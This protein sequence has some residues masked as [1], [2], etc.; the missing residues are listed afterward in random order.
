MLFLKVYFLSVFD[1]PPLI[2]KFSPSVLPSRFPPKNGVVLL[3]YVNRCIMC[4]WR[5]KSYNW[6]WNF[7]GNTTLHKCAAF[8]CFLSPVKI[9][10]L[11]ESIYVSVSVLVGALCSDLFCLT[12]VGERGREWGKHVGSVTEESQVRGCYNIAFNYT[13]QETV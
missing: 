12:F 5:L 10:A 1:N 7:C 8:C 2:L 13:N 11:D 6:V 4:P 3:L 9:C